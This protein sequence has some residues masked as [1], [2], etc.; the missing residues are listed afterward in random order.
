M[1][2]YLAPGVYI[3]EL[4]SGSR[5]IAPVGTS[6]A[7]F[8]GVAQ[9]GPVN[10]ATL[11]TNFSDFQKIFGGPY[12]VLKGTQEFYLFYSVQHFFAQGGT[13]CYIVRIVHYGDPEVANT[14][15]ATAAARDFNGTLADNSAVAPALTISAISPGLWGSQELE[16]QVVTSSKFTA[17]L[18]ADIVAG[19]ATQTALQFNDQI[20]VG[21]LL[22]VVEEVVGHVAAV[23]T[24][25]GAV[26]FNA[27]NLL[28]AGG[29]PFNGSIATSI[30]VF[31]PAFG[32]IGATVQAAA[33]PV[34]AGVPAP[35]NGIVVSTVGKVDG[36]TLR[37]GDVLTFAIA[38]ARLFVTR[39]DVQAGATVV[40]FAS[41]TLPAFTQ[42]RSR[43]YA[44]DFT[45]V[46][47]SRSVVVETD[48]NLVTG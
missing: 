27:Q 6:T 8:I 4:P 41:Q 43:V 13:R 23:D 30:P 20:Q 1:P 44:R 37:P 31:G 48:P 42:A 45:V 33:V 14:I 47:R 40:Q 9:K 21:S 16:A 12:R 17:L 5:P 10:Q 34:V 15:A 19:A 3:E 29:A 28:T 38:Q 26:T 25:T 39:V 2:S 7:A 22:W 11:I 35:A 36:S 18:N 24:A 32:Y 46:V